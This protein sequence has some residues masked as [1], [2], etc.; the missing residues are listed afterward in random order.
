MTVPSRQRCPCLNECCCKGVKVSEPTSPPQPPLRPTQ[1]W[2]ISTNPALPF[3]CPAWSLCSPHRRSVAGR[4]FE[5]FPA[6]PAT[7]RPLLHVPPAHPPG[8][9]SFGGPLAR[10]HHTNRRLRPHWYQIS[11]ARASFDFQR[12]WLGH[13]RWSAPPHPSSARAVLSTLPAPCTRVMIARWEGARRVPPLLELASFRLPIQSQSYHE[14]CHDYQLRSST[15]KSFGIPFR[16]SKR[17][18]GPTTPSPHVTKLF[19]MGQT[20]S[21]RVH[22]GRG[23]QTV[24]SDRD[25]SPGRHHFVLPCHCSW[26]TGQRTHPRIM[27]YRS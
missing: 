22:S 3:V 26:T 4:R 23:G 21:V 2:P 6:K 17:A 10:S 1:L 19:V 24:V 5:F 20:L 11:I 18:S 8:R 25:C 7:P 15:H 14:F 9:P 16:P 13:P 27:H 12:C